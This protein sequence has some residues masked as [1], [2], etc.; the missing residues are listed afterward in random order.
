MKALDIRETM[1]QYVVMCMQ[2]VGCDGKAVD[3]DG[4]FKNADEAREYVQLVE[5]KG[6][7]CSGPHRILRLKEV[8]MVVTRQLYTQFELEED[9]PCCGE[10]EAGRD[11]T[12]RNPPLF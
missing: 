10:C 2:F 6:L 9:D 8:D 5:S 4:P 12:N 1:M 3:V 11:C 7:Q